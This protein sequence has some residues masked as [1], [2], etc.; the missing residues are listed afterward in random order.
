MTELTL[1]DL[2]LLHDLAYWGLG[3]VRATVPLAVRRESYREHEAALDKMGVL[4]EEMKIDQENQERL[5][6]E[7]RE[8]QK[9]EQGQ[10]VAGSGQEAPA[11]D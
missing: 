2:Q 10:P 3:T 7:E 5:L 6:R 1:T 4:M 8:R 11:G 9:L